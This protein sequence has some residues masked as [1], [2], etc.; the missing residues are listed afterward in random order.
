[1]PPVSVTKKEPEATHETLHCAN[2]GKEFPADHEDP[3]SEPCV[4]P[5]GTA[6][7]LHGNL[8]GPGAP[9]DEK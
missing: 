3:N 1:M 9:K 8:D 2:C 6:H 5:A 7:D 4:G